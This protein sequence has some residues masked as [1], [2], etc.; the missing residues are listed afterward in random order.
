[1]SLDVYTVRNDFPALGQLVHGHYPLVYRDNAAT[2]LKP[3]PVVDA[4]TQYY[5]V[6]TGNIHRGVHQLSI[7]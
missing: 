5:R 6:D 2:T 4:M 1:M 3:R 7:I